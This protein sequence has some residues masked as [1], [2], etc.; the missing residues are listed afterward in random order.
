MNADYKNI[1]HI[2]NP[3]HFN[4]RCACEFDPKRGQRGPSRHGSSQ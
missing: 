3:G 1:M 2:P 4:N